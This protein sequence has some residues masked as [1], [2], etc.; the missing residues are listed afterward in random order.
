MDFPL[1]ALLCKAPMRASPY[2]R[3]AVVSFENRA[4]AGSA[5]LLIALMVCFVIA[6]LFLRFMRAYF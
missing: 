4:G 2:L 3:R 1:A 5:Y 6:E